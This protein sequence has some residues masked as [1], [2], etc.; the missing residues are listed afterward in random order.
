MRAE[1]ANRKGRADAHGFTRRGTARDPRA[2]HGPPVPHGG[3]NP[4]TPSTSA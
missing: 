2:A 3:W 4:G 1:R